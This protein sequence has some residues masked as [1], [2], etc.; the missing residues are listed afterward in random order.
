MV[1]A[2]RRVGRVVYMSVG[3]R[4]RYK[5]WSAFYKSGCRFG[6]L[7]VEHLA[8]VR[9]H[10]FTDGRSPLERRDF[11]RVSDLTANLGAPRVFAS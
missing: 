4:G 2:V 8:A 1:R 9:V 11:G 10:Q 5:S 7:T 3:G 6:A